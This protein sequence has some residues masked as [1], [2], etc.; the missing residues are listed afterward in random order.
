MEMPPPTRDA[1]LPKHARE[2]L[3]SGFVSTSADARHDL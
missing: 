1:G 3:L 2:L